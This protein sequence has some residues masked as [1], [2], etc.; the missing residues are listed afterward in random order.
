VPV[1]ADLLKSI[2]KAYHADRL[3]LSNDGNTREIIKDHK[4]NGMDDS[5]FRFHR[6][7]KRHFLSERQKDLSDFLFLHQALLTWF[8]KNVPC[9]FKVR[10]GAQD[11]TRFW[12]LFSAT[13][14]PYPKSATA[15]CDL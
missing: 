7:M 4:F 9:T 8:E 10:F 13:W 1:K 5:V 11:N 6:G 12:V 15:E 14:M 3:V 2:F